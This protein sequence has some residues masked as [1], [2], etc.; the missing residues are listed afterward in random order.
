MYMDVF[1]VCATIWEV[2][3]PVEQHAHWDRS[4]AILS[5]DFIIY[6]NIPAR[7]NPFNRKL[8]CVLVVLMR[9]CKHVLVA[10]RYHSANDTVFCLLKRLDI[11]Q[12]TSRP[13]SSVPFYTS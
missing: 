2:S 4:T 3:S 11:S 7:Q 9:K 8:K 10:S 5:E 6:L 12:L 1:G 13:K